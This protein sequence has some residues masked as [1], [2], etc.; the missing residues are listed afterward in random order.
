[1]IF[2]SILRE[3]DKFQFHFFSFEETLQ[4]IYLTLIIS[5]KKTTQLHV[6]E[7]KTIFIYVLTV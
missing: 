4:L 2:S 5:L 6:N 3:S 1:M 7:K